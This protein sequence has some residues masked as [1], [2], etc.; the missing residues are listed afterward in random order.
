MEILLTLIIIPIIWLVVVGWFTGKKDYIFKR[1]D[2]KNKQRI[3]Q[4]AVVQSWAVL[5][6]FLLTNF[7]FDVF[8]LG[9]P[10]LNGE[11]LY[12]ELFYLVVVVLSYFFFYFLNLKRAGAVEG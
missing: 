9:D 4:K 10:R 11:A 2:D 12:P 3:K 1:N 5:L 8:N 7:L 6:L